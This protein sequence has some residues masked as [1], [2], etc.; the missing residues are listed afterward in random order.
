MEPLITIAGG[1]GTSDGAA[2]DDLAR[3]RRERFAMQS[4]VPELRRNDLRSEKFAIVHEPTGDE[5]RIYAGEVEAGPTHP[6]HAFFYGST[7]GI[8]FL[9]KIGSR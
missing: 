7:G 3:R 5:Y 2:R 8:V 1:P 4:G 6:I 9:E